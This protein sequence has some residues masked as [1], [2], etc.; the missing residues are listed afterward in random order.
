[1]KTIIITTDF[2]E[3][4]LN[5]AR[6]AA[7]LAKSVEANQIVL[8]HAYDNLPIGT[9]LPMTDAAPSLIEKQSISNLEAV[10]QELIQILGGNS[11]VNIH[12]VTNN[13]P[14]L[15]GIEGL[16]EKWD[17]DL[18]VVG[19]TGRSNL[20]QALI[21]SNTANL[22]SS[23]KQPLLIV[24]NHVGYEPIHK[25]VFACDL[26]KVSSNTPVAEIT[27][28]LERLRAKLLVLNVMPEGERA[29][30]DTTTEQYKINALLE[31]VQPEYHYTT[32]NDIA[33]E[34]ETFAEY[35][36]AGLI[37]TIPKSYG[38]F[39]R[40]FRRSVSKQLIKKSGIP[41]LLLRETEE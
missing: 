22:A 16:L 32:G 14:L 31:V 34:I 1:M 38:F 21:G 3:S 37:V 40:L 11:T 30:P 29:N 36:N 25:I 20:E 19:A 5:A 8:Y 15:H 39:E 35:H 23:L 4:A 13:F 6:Y 24:P 41:L 12:M 28:W 9:D 2:S 27:Q 33:E 17:A 7:N 26:R 10:Q 18:V